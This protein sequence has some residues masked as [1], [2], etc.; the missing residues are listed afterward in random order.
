M[1][2]E[3]SL[4]L[5]R[6]LFALDVILIGVAWI[7]AWFIRFDVLPAAEHAPLTRYLEFLPA[8]LVIW[9]AVFL[10]SGLYQTRRA[11]RLTLVVYA[12]ARAIF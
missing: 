10:L 9:S 5:Q 6:L 12:V 2:R 4:L 7:V 3:R 8:V 1:L 11:Q